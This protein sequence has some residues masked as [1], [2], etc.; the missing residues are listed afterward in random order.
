[1]E[2]PDIF[3]V[4]AMVV[5]GSEAIL[6]QESR[7]QTS[8][9]GSDTLPSKIIGDL[10]E[11]KILEDAGF[12]FLGPVEGDKLFQYVKLPAG[13]KKEATDH[14]MWSNLVDEKG[15][16]RAT[17]FYKAA[18]Y[19]RDAFIRLKTRFGIQYEYDREDTEHVAVASVTD[20]GK[21]VH[22]TEPL[23]LPEDDRKKYEASDK[24]KEAARTWLDENYQDWKNP[25]ACW[26]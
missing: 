6:N 12:Q 23:P 10:T 21:V 4:E 17:I 16:I 22:T 20:C 8:F 14:S 13:W 25:G 2:N 26:D 5:G 1:M 24:A 9:V 7:G 3:R 15:R 19:D 18:F 11:K